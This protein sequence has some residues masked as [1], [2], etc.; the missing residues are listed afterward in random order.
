MKQ[1]LFL[2]SGLTK[3]E[4]L[5]LPNETQSVDKFRQTSN[6]THVVFSKDVSF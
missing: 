2:E 4:N 5:A 6:S 1:C 3:D